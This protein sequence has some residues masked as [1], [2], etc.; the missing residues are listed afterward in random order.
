MYFPV[1]LAILARWLKTL[2]PAADTSVAGL[3]ADPSAA[4]VACP[5]SAQL[6]PIRLALICEATT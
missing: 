4:C 5:P 6:G 3:M 2:D 1:K